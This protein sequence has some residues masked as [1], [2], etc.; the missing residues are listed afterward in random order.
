MRENCTSA[1]DTDL[2]LCLFP[3]GGNFEL[4]NGNNWCVPDLGKVL[5]LTGNPNENL[6]ILSLFLLFRLLFLQSILI[7]L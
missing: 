7:Q 3:I 5:R 1:S 2:K 6:S 4:A